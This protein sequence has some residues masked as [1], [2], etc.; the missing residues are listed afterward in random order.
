[1][2]DFYNNVAKQSRYYIKGNIHTSLSLHTQWAVII[3]ENEILLV[4][5]DIIT[6]EYYWKK[7]IPS[8]PP[9]PALASC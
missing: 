9:S 2:K 5:F 1:M 7:E 6:L 4:L 8:N 3:E